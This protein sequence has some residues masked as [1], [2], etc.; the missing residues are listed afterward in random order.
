MLYDQAFYW[1]AIPAVLLVG[2]AKGGMGEALGLMGVPIL[3]F[4]VDPVTAAAIMLPIM[5]V[6]DLM[7]LWIWRKHGDLATLKFLLPG[8]LLG[9]A[10]GWATAAYLP[11]YSMRL[12]IGVIAIVFAGRFFFNRYLASHLN[13]RPAAAHS[14]VKAGIWGSLAGYGSFVAHSGGAPYQVY[15][16]PLKL[17]PRNYIG[18]TVRFFAI[19]N[20]LKLFPYFALGELD[21]SNLELSATLFPLG[22]AATFVGSMI[23]KR[24]RV[25][26]FYPYMYAMVG[27]A[28]IKLF[29]DGA[30]PLIGL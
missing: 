14:I 23:V 13:D 27:L 4:G 5:V 20:V 2:L 22:L 19:L 15:V 6:M 25:E 9:I 29:Y 1:A 18:V 16:L 30:K 10:F 8:G 21:F 26:A 7:S 12:L 17:E 28:G 24:M 3:S 11:A